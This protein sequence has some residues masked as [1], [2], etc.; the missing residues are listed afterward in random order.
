[1][2]LDVVSLSR[3]FEG[4][5]FTYR[6]RSSETATVMRFAAFI[7]PQADQ[8]PVPVVW[9]L[10]GL[11]CTEENFTVKA[12]AQRIAVEPPLLLVAADTSPPGDGVP[13]GPAG[14]YDLG[15]GGGVYVHAKQP[16]PS[17]HYKMAGYI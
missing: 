8:Q 6:H 5:Q 14:P 11:T 7:P 17:R 15:L 9:Y 2:P 3:C 12:G 4:I 10:S 13:S 1:M 16:P